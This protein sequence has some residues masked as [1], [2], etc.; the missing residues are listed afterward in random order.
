MMVS[1]FLLYSPVVSKPTNLFYV[2]DSSD[3]VTNKTFNYFKQFVHEDLRTKALSENSL[4]ASL[5]AYGSSSVLQIAPTHQKSLLKV[6][7]CI[8][9]FISCWNILVNGIRS[10]YLFVIDI[11]SKDF[12]TILF[13]GVTLREGDISAV[14]S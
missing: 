12:L 3:G 13:V 2:L 8:S 11:K 6:N 4:K 9:F 5:L 1:H 10:I 14:N 7:Y